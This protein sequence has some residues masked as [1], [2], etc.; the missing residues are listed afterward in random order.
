[1]MNN[2]DNDHIE[3]WDRLCDTRYEDLTEKEKDSSREWARKV[4]DI[5]PMRGD[6]KQRILHSVEGGL[7]RF[8]NAKTGPQR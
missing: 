7:N 3:Q 2:F 1:M 4:I 6:K 8:A 5:I